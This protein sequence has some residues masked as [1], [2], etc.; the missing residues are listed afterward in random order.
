M[1]D[2]V[3]ILLGAT[4]NIICL[5]A[6][7]ALQIHVLGLCLMPPIRGFSYSLMEHYDSISLLVTFR[8]ADFFPPK[9][10]MLNIIDFDLTHDAIN[11]MLTLHRHQN[12]AITREP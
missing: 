11:D 3:L 9:Q 10:V 12:T 2:H 7:E 5:Y 8:A 6:F 1:L 4:L